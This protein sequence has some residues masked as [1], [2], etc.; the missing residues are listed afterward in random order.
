LFWA[1]ALAAFWG[2]LNAVVSDARLFNFL[3]SYAAL[4]ATFTGAIWWGIALSQP[5]GPVRNFLFTWSLAPCL[6][7]WIALAAPRPWAL[8]GLGCLLGFQLL[9]DY[10]FLV[11]PGLVMPWVWR[12]RRILTLMAMSSLFF[13]SLQTWN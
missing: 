6:L 2:G 4:I 5:C 3:A 11:K 13:A 8:L 12:L 9:M 1:L 7:A 10:K